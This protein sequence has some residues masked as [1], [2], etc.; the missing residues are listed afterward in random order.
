FV[1]ADV[2]GH[3]GYALGGAIPI[4]AKG[5]G[6]LP[7]PGW[8]GEYEWQGT[9]P[10]EALPHAFDPEEGLLVTANNRIVDSS[11]PYKIEGEYLSGYRAA[12]I[13]QM[14]EQTPQH[15]LDSFGRIHRD[16]RSLPGLEMVALVGRLPNDTPFAAQVRD[17]LATWDGDMSPDSAGAL[18][19]S[20]LRE[21]LLDD[22]FHEID[23]VAGAAFGLGA[24]AGLPGGDMRAIA[25][26][27]ILRRIAERDDRW[28]GGRNS[29]ET[30]LAECWRATITELRDTYGEDPANWRYGEAHKID[31]RHALGSV[32]PL[33]P[34]LNRGPFEYRGDRDTVSMGHSPKTASGQEMFVAP[35]YRQICDTADWNRSR[36]SHPI[37]QSGHPG[38]AHYADFV[39]AWLEG[40]YHP[41]PW[42]RTQVEEAA[43]ARLLLEPR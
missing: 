43:A 34:L 26:P 12:R 40:R 20:R 39:E 17:I 21:R 18:I 25:L 13:R 3:I 32:A 28:F 37:G 29:W 36:S 8:S 14:L 9:V 10:N 2:D 30:V 24:F 42:S 16:A 4:R 27:G 22:A 31:L 5:D 41:M 38:S 6:R 11:F 19:F 15:T 23:G 33:A 35:S 1:Y 7:V